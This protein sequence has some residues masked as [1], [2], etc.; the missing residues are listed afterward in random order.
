RADS[1]RI[2]L[3]RGLV[4]GHLQMVASHHRAFTTAQKAIGDSFATTPVGLAGTE[5]L[6][7]LL[8]THGVKTGKLSLNQLV[9]VL[10]GHPAELFGLGNKGTIAIGKDADLVIFNPQDKRILTASALHSESGYTVFDGW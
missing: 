2:A 4:T 7:P 3:W 10:A 9:R 1:D 8:Y 6:L 5:T